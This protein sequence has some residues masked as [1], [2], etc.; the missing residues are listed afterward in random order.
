MCILPMNMYLLYLIRNQ[1]NKFHTGPKL[2]LQNPLNL[3][4]I[5]QHCFKLILKTDA[6]SPVTMETQMHTAGPICMSLFIVHDMAYIAST[7]YMMVMRKCGLVFCI[8]L[9][10]NHKRNGNFTLW[11]FIRCFA[12]HTS[13][14][15]SNVIL[16]PSGS[17]TVL[18]C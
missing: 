15:A 5:L 8:I 2:N 18:E 7:I 13:S 16:D 6:T 4:E 9:C 10:F 17:L 14:G 12:L 11:T 3:F 1:W